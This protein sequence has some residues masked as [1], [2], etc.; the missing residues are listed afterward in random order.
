MNF[1]SIIGA[2]TGN[3]GG[4]AALLPLILSNDSPLGGVSGLLDKFKEQGLGD[5]ASSWLGSGENLPI[6]G[7]QLK[8]VLGDDIV[9]TATEQLGV[10]E[11]ET[12]D[13][14]TSALPNAIDQLTPDGALPDSGFG[15][16]DILNI[17]KSLI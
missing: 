11:S 7:E 9:K 10:G 12:L 6:S 14:L 13:T 1:G 15:V 2:V 4:L 8:S 16:T 3:G 5:V 17:A